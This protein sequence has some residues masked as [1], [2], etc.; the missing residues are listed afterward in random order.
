MLYGQIHEVAVSKY[1]KKMGDPLKITGA[2]TIMAKD[3]IQNSYAAILKYAVEKRINIKEFQE[4][5]L[6]VAI[7]S[8]N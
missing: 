1:S 3:A 8:I 6:L 2:L 5:Q 7:E 4:N